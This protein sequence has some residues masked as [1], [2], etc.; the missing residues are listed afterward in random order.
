MVRHS[1]VLSVE[2]CSIKLNKD[3]PHWSMHREIRIYAADWQM[4]AIQ[5]NCLSVTGRI[6]IAPW[7]EL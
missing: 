6:T 7:A 1:I 3:F 5:T 2:P 4:P